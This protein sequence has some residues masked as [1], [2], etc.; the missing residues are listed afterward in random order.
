[1]VSIIFITIVELSKCSGGGLSNKRFSNNP[2]PPYTNH[3]R[4]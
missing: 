3:Y 1:V 2:Q 4:P